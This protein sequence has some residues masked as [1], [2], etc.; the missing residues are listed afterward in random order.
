LKKI[1]ALLTALLLLSGVAYASIPDASGVIHGCVKNGTT[2]QR[3]IR[4]IDTAYTTVCSAGWTAVTWNQTGPQGPVGA[5]GPQG[6]AGPAGPQGPVGPTGATNATYYV[7]IDE[8]QTIGGG[9]SNAIQ[10]TCPAPD[11]A[12]GGTW[13]LRTGSGGDPDLAL[14]HVQTTDFL[15][16]T[17]GRVYGYFAQMWA[18]NGVGTYTVVVEVV[19]VHYE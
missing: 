16:D 12:T 14:I 15:V 8:A 1:A 6:P 19:C 9:G 4:V 5:T 7:R 2:G 11:I 18:E 10:V 3:E 13:K 17:T